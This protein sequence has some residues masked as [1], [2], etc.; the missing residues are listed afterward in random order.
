MIA[1]G[2]LGR[3][4]GGSFDSGGWIKLLFDTNNQLLDARID[5]YQIN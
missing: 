5:A 2:N 1:I 4:C 3:R